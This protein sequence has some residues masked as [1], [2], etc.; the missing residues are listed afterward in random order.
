MSPRRIHGQTMNHGPNFQT[1]TDP[2]A[3]GVSPP[4][5]TLTYEYPKLKV[6]RLSGLLV[7]ERLFSNALITHK[8]NHRP[9]ASK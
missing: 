1:I 5:P 4:L 2:D 9:N 6:G 7:S 8:I 3:E